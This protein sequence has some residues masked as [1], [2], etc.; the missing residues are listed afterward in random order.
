VV[1]TLATVIQWAILIV[2]GF[3]AGR[4]MLLHWLPTA[5]LMVLSVI[6]WLLWPIFRAGLTILRVR[7]DA[8]LA[9]RQWRA[10]LK[11]A[12]RQWKTSPWR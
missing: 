7:M 6:I 8:K 10:K 12:K 1:V 2:V 5:F 11:L 3:V 4:W 9:K